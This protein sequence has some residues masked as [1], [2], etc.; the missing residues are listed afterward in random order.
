MICRIFSS[1]A[2]WSYGYIGFVLRLLEV[3]ARVD[4]FITEEGRLIF[5]TDY[6]LSRSWALCIFS[7]EGTFFTVYV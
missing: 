1:I 6:L 5:L 2:F 3:V 7:T 4:L